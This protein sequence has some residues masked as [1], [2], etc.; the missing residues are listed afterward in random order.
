LICELNFIVENLQVFKTVVKNIKPHI[1]I[2]DFKSQVLK[3][4]RLGKDYKRH[5][6]LKKARSKA[7]SSKANSKRNVSNNLKGQDNG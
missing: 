7:H 1:K 5:S 3:K 2:K 6:I 4:H